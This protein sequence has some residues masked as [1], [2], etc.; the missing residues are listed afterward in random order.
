VDE[1]VE[2][3]VVG[4]VVSVLVGWGVFG[5][6]FDE[7]EGDDEEEDYEDGDEEGVLVIGVDHESWETDSYF[8]EGFAVGIAVF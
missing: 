8:Y 3:V 2:E 4:E 5:D 7:E 6:P 1:G